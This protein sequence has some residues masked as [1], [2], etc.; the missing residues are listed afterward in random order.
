MTSLPSQC[1]FALNGYREYLRALAAARVEG[2]VRAHLDPSDIVQ[3]TLLKAYHGREQFR[4]RTE[5]ELVAWLRA[6]LNNTLAN[7]LRSC[8]RQKSAGFARAT[9]QADSSSARRDARPSDDRP[10]ADEVAIRNE[11][12]LLVAR[13]LDQL[14][15]DQRD[16]VEMKY[17]QGLTVPEICDCTGRS[18]GSVV[19]LLFRGM[20]ALRVLLDEPGQESVEFDPKPGGPAT[21]FPEPEDSV[22]QES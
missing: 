3:E 19:G 15:A 18:K 5:Q 22:S 1:S 21:R 20:R 10:R 16:V 17:L 4:G 14:P 9:E 7:A 11:Q 2:R 13:A 6:I 12:L 8:S